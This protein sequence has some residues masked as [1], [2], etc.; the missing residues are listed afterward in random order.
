[1][2]K[3]FRIVAAVCVAASVVYSPV[4]SRAAFPGDNG[5]IAF[6]AANTRFG[7]YTMSP[8]GSSQVPLTTNRFDTAPEWSPDGSRI[9]FESEGDIF[10]MNADGTGRTN[11]TNSP[12]PID[13]GSPTWSPDGQF[14]AFASV[15]Q[16]S[17]IYAMN[18]D[19]S[20]G[21]VQL[22][23]DTRYDDFPSW[24]PDGSTIAF[25]AARAGQRGLFTMPANTGEPETF[26]QLV[27]T[28]SNTRFDWAPDSS[29]IAY[30]TDLNLWTVNRDGSVPLQLTFDDTA[31]SNGVAWSPDGTQ[32][33]YASQRNTDWDI[34]VTSATQPDTDGLLSVNATNTRGNDFFPDWGVARPVPG[35][36]P[37][38]PGTTCGTGGDDDIDVTVDASSETFDIQ[39]GDGADTI[40]LHIDDPTDPATVTI[41]TGDAGDTVI[42]PP[43]AGAVTVQIETGLGNDVVRLGARNSTARVAAQQAGARGYVVLTAGGNDR[44][45]VG[46]AADRVDGGPG[47]DTVNGAGGADRLGGGEGGDDLE[48]GGGNDQMNG[49][50][51]TDVLHGSDGRNVFNGG[52]GRD[53]CLS[54]AR[55]DRFRSCERIRRNHRRNHQQV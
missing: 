50:G 13:D 15:R 49:G 43:S 5:P 54:D 11:L 34:Y 9:V 47:R 42:V 1:V 31:S 24:S 16:N 20:G 25:F 22:T 7:I 33:A 23:T 6:H 36:D 3:S 44:V 38:Q 27:S 30:I 28:N 18:A 48:G 51:G 29:R 21:E 39:T 53:T 26:V 10:V 2:R 35:C 12:L 37:Q 52:S 55:Q 46:G 45:T 8:D 32:I 41:D 4:P 40:E 17:D 19:G 14:I